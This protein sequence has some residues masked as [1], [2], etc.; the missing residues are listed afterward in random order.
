VSFLADRTAACRRIVTSVFVAP[1]YYTAIL[2]SAITAT[3]ERLVNFL[4]WHIYDSTVP[5]VMWP[6]LIS[7]T[8]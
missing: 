8:F 5:S 2:R 7:A 1:L 6:K 3:A 4:S